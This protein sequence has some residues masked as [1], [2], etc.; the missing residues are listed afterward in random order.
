MPMR[1][2]V[3]SWWPNL[4]FNGSC[5]YQGHPGAWK[6]WE[7]LHIKP[8]PPKDST[9]KT[10]PEKKSLTLREAW[11]GIFLSPPL[12]WVESERSVP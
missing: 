10:E 8:R 3:I 1:A 7:I 9:L 2:G 6:D 4:G 5:R 11:E 12:L